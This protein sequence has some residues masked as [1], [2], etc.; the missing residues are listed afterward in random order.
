MTGALIIGYGVALLLGSADPQASVILRWF[1]AL[2]HNTI[3]ASAETA[4]PVAVL[5]HVLAGIGWAAVYAAFA[6]PRLSGPGWRRGLI[7]APIPWVLSLIVFLP[8]AG[9]GI[10]GLG[11]G[12]GP[13]PILGNLVVHLVYGPTLGFLYA[14][15][16]ARVLHPDDTAVTPFEQSMMARSER[17][18]ATGMLV[19][20]VLGAIVGWVIAFVLAPGQSGLVGMLLGALGGSAA[21]LLVGSYSGLTPT[22][23]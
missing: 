18:M 16:N 9:G 1:W 8:L 17:T 21:G 10:L 20:L 5:L 14:P 23:Q 6:E 4:V 19:G 13:L 7:F 12:A 3:T 22:R 15:E 11:L 2:A